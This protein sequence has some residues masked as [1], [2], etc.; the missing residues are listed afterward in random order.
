MRSCNIRHARIYATVL[1]FIIM[2]MAVPAHAVSTADI[3]DE[4]TECR[5]TLTDADK[6][7]RQHGTAMIGDNTATSRICTSRP[8]R[9]ITPHGPAP[10][11][12]HA[13]A[14]HATAHH[15]NNNHKRH[16]TNCSATSP[17]RMVASR[18]YY[19]IALRR[20]LC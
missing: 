20:I 13:R 8:S 18:H 1:T 4:G 11:K 16:T 5:D 17:C 19:V 9:L 2:M 15:I 7:D 6:H 3:Q 10:E 14:S 12:L